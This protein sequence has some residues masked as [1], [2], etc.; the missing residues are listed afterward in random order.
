MSCGKAALGGVG[1]KAGSIL[2]GLLRENEGEFEGEFEGEL[3]GE[4]EGERGECESER[5]GSVILK[6]GT[7]WVELHMRSGADLTLFFKCHQR[8]S[9]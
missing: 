2:R 9:S 4:Y 3:E 8:F 7:A 1:G 5:E 6:S